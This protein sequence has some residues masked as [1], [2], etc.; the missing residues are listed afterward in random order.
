MANTN[1][2]PAPTPSTYTSLNSAALHAIN[3]TD[4]ND[5]EKLLI[6]NNQLVEKTTNV[7][8]NIG[9]DTASIA[10]LDSQQQ[11]LETSL[12]LITNV[13]NDLNTQ[14]TNLGN[15]KILI[16]GREI[17]LRTWINNHPFSVYNYSNKI[18]TIQVHYSSFGIMGMRIL[19]KVPTKASETIGIV[20]GANTIQ[21]VNFTDDEW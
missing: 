1:P 9:T 5:L 16:N 18:S 21:S 6:N 14:K 20:S 4:L 8:N 19:Y 3:S 15:K 13:K 12:T 2:T 7:L 17:T 11:A 10:E